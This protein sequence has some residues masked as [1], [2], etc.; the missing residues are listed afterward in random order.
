MSPLIACGLSR[1]LD[2]VGKFGIRPLLNQTPD[3]E[4]W[5]SASCRG[6]RRRALLSAPNG[7]RR[8]TRPSASRPAALLAPAVA[9][10]AREVLRAGPAL[11]APAT[12]AP[13]AC[14]HWHS[15]RS[16]RAR[17]RSLLSGPP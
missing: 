10:P 8:H 17:A 15:K 7:C 4:R 13:R 5:S 6:V 9:L 16:V 11:L 12:V 1:N 14:A 3:T 2:F